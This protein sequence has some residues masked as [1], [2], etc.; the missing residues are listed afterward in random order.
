MFKKLPIF[1]LLINLLTTTFSFSQ[2]G[3]GTTTPNASLEIT[4]SNILAP[5]NTDGILI[6]RV[7]ILPL[8]NPGAAQDSMLIFLT[9]TVGSNAPGFYYWEN[10]TTSWI[11]FGKVKRIN[12]LLDGKSD[13]DGS[14]DGSSVFLGINSGAGDDST[15]NKNTATGFQTLESNVI[16]ENNTAY[17]YRSLR[18]N[19]ADQNTAFGSSTLI[20]NITGSKNT[21]IGTIALRDNISGESNVAIGFLSLTENI[22]GRNNIAM[23]N[24]S[25]RKNIFSEN[26]VAIG[27]YAGRSLDLNNVT[28]LD[29]DQNVFVGGGAGNSDRNSTR[30]V[31][32]GFEAGAGDYNINLATGT[33]EDKNGNIFIGFQAGYN[34]SGNEK[35]YIENSNK[36]SNNALM[37][38]EFDND[39][40]RVNGTFQISNPA[41]TGYALPTADGTANQ[42]LT[43]DGNGSV[44]W[45]NAGTGGLA[46]CNTNLSGNQTIS[47][48]STWTKM[49]FDTVDFDLN[50]DFDTGNNEFTV[51]ADGIYRITAM[52][53]SSANLNNSNTFGIR[54]TAGGNNIQEVNY[55]HMNENS[56]VVRQVSSLTQLNTGDTIEIQ[57]RV[58]SASGLTIDD[59]SKFTNFSVE[60]VR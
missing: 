9:T 28:D 12:D 33:L 49:E 56:V 24:Q 19:T 44:S 2:V 22:S 11:P 41:G 37:Y 32:L 47:S 25:L 26:N 6:P 23:G 46:I 45:G 34:E 4:A 14:E 59:N 35:L 20:D 57:A 31:Y 5:S 38:G 52:Y 40:L 55:K 60:R 36:D 21:A 48:A 7:N 53:T 51:P 13:I 50:T 43:T 3:I 1:I 18:L 58:N 42:V 10:A 54:I 15:D 39:L 8:T 17:G 29:N 16:G 27:D 30:N